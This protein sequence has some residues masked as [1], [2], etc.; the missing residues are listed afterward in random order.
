MKEC[1][2]GVRF[3]PVISTICILLLDFFFL[4]FLKG[5]PLSLHLMIQEARSL[6]RYYTGIMKLR[7]IFHHHTDGKNK[8]ML[9]WG[10]FKNFL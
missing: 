6:Y 9:V 3:L 1:L 10:F 2:R 8:I 7:G 5:L 4:P